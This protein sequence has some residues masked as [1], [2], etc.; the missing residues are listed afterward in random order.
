MKT[1]SQCGR[2][3]GLR[4]CIV[5][6]PPN[7]VER[8]VAGIQKVLRVRVDDLGAVHARR[9][10]LCAQG[11]NRTRLRGDVELPVYPQRV[12]LALQKLSERR[13]FLLRTFQ[14]TCSKS[15]NRARE[16]TRIDKAPESK[17]DMCEAMHSACSIP[18]RESIVLS[19][20]DRWERIHL[21]L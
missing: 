15:L 20:S 10:Q 16:R 21:Y 7:K 14:S 5:A 6:S 8:F 19:T 13:L 9:A 3:H 12:V 18:A 4:G 11:V 17:N 2:S 1:R